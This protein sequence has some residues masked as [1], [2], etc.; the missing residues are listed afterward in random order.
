M[1]D[2]PARRTEASKRREGRGERPAGCR[3]SSRCSGRAAGGCGAARGRRAGAACTAGPRRRPGAAQITCQPPARAPPVGTV[4]S[5]AAAA[6][7]HHL[8][9]QAGAARP[10]LGHM[11]PAPAGVP[12]TYLWRFSSIRQPC[13]AVQRW[14]S[15][16][17][18]RFTVTPVVANGQMRQWMDPRSRC[19]IRQHGTYRDRKSLPATFFPQHGERTTSHCE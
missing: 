8:K 5:S 15:L 18:W 11:R 19:Q 12:L 9:R 3:R 14:G 6:R 2:G 13:A 10:G 16:W 7:S 17:R 1:G 4:S